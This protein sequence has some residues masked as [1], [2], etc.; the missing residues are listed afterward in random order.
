MLSATPSGRAA[1]GMRNDVIKRQLFHAGLLA[2]VLARVVVTLEN[3]PP[4]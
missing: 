1:L 4:T 3:V 2:T